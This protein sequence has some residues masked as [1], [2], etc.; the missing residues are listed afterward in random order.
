[1]NLINNKYKELWIFT[2]CTVAKWF[3]DLKRILQM[4]ELRYHF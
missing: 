2:T 1:M 4:L 3:S